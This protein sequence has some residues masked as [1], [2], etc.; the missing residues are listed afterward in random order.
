[1]AGVP[2]RGCPQKIRH[3]DDG[4]RTKKHP[5]LM[6]TPFSFSH[7]KLDQSVLILLIETYQSDRV[8]SYQRCDESTKYDIHLSFSAVSS[9]L[10][11]R[12][13]LIQR[14]LDSRDPGEPF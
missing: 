9:R 14:A 12:K 10:T 7:T 2:V 8:I 1:M 6:G 13:R 11:H 5:P 3:D 4:P